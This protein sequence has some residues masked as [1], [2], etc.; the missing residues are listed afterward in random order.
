MIIFG[1]SPCAFIWSCLFWQLAAMT[2]SWEASCP[3]TLSTQSQVI[4]AHWQQC[5]TTFFNILRSFEPDILINWTYNTTASWQSFD[6][7]LLLPFSCFLC[8]IHQLH[9]MVPA[10]SSCSS[11]GRPNFHSGLKRLCAPFFTLLA[12]PAFGEFCA[13]RF[14]GFFPP[15]PG[16]FPLEL[17]F[18]LAPP[19]VVNQFCIIYRE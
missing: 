11:H 10:D 4:S 9:V 19:L 14:G 16:C 1:M 12:G 15:S 3:V 17:D 2:W 13:G 7:H 6:N 18:V 5:T 8:V